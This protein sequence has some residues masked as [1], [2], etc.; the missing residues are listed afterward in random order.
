MYSTVSP[1]FPPSLHSFPFFSQGG[2]FV[3]SVGHKIFEANKENKGRAI[4]INLKGLGIGN[5]LTGKKREGGRKGGRDM[6]ERGGKKAFVQRKPDIIKP[7]SLLTTIT[8]SLL[9]SL[10]PSL[11]PDPELQYQFYGDYARNNS[12]GIELVS[13]DD[14]QKM[15]AGREGGREGRLYI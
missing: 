11:L 6:R 7:I 9:P 5:G 3:P 1:P 15:D 8:P 14:A 13:A 2:H 10:P 4:Q 12:Y